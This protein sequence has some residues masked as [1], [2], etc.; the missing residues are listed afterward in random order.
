MGCDFSLQTKQD[1][2]QRISSIKLSSESVKKSQKKLK[3]FIKEFDE[4]TSMPNVKTNIAQDLENSLKKLEELLKATKEK[5]KMKS[6]DTIPILIPKE[7]PKQFLSPEKRTLK[8]KNKPDLKLSKSHEAQ[9]NKEKIS[10]GQRR[11]SVPKNNQQSILDDPEIVA[12]ITKNKQLL[13]RQLT[14]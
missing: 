7:P 4:I 1:F 3:T 12:L 5:Q 14:R 13:M 8:K 2:M 9:N 11:G 6:S 10:L